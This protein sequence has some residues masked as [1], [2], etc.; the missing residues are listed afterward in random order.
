M[1]ERRS[2]N[3]IVND[4]RRDGISTGYAISPAT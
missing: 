1:C 3:R 2:V 4:L